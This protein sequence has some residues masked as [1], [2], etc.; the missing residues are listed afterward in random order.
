MLESFSIVNTTDPADGRTPTGFHDIE[1]HD[2]YVWVL[3]FWSD[4]IYRV[5]PSQVLDENSVVIAEQGHSDFNIPVPDN[6]PNSGTNCDTQA[7]CL[8]GGSLT[9]ANSFFWNAS[10]ET[11]DIIKLDPVDGG[12]LESENTLSTVPFPSPVGM[13]YD[14]TNFWIVDWQSNTINRVR[15]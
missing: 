2:G 15:P 6:I 9:F 11:D 8:G 1:V 7:T 12:N 4:R 3:D 14:G 5:Y 10:A 13:T